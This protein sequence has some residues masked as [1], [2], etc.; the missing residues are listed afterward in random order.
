MVPQQQDTFMSNEEHFVMDIDN[1]MMQKLM[2]L[3]F[4]KF[5]QVF[6]VCC[7]SGSKDDASFNNF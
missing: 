2:E 1:F 7:D 3:Y 5:N 6:P 4:N